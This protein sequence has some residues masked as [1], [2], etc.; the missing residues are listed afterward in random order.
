MPPLTAETIKKNFADSDVIYER[1]LGIY[2]NGAFL[3]KESDT[4]QQ[5]FLYAVDGSYGDYLTQVRLAEDRIEVSCSCPDYA[6]NRQWA[7]QAA[8]ET[9]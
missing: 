1:G 7:R 3:L 5:T 6:G 8:G 4:D 9:L 2:Q